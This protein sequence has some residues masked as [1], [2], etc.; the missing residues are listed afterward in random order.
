MTYYSVADFFPVLFQYAQSHLVSVKYRYWSVAPPGF[1]D[2]I[3]TVTLS[4]VQ[5]YICKCLQSW[6]IFILTVTRI[7]F[8]TFSKY[9]QQKHCIKD[10]QK[11]IFI[12]VDTINCQESWLFCYHVCNPGCD[13][14]TIEFCWPP[15]QN[16]QCSH[17]CKCHSFNFLHLDSCI[18]HNMMQL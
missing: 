3:S 5:P 6:D 2:Y 1:G 8:S 17:R 12:L 11:G 10:Y 9:L 18:R 4:K 16:A 14:A 7:W 13:M 15:V